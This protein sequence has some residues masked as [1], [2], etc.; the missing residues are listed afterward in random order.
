MKPTQ[1]ESSLT[2]KKQSFPSLNRAR[3]YIFIF[4]D[5]TLPFFFDALDVGVPV[6]LRPHVGSD[7]GSGAERAQSASRQSMFS[8]VL[9]FHD[10]FDVFRQTR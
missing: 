8:S 3:K 4:F 2:T 10:M 9:N 1:P 6:L 7:R 5:K